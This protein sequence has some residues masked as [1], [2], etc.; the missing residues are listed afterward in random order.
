MAKYIEKYCINA[1]L[2]ISGCA[3]YAES[4]TGNNLDSP[5]SENEIESSGNSTALSEQSLQTLGLQNRVATLESRVCQYNI[6][7]VS[8][9]IDRLLCLAELNHNHCFLFSSKRLKPFSS[10]YTTISS[11]IM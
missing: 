4:E 6:I 1:I 5:V 10:D 9:I 3:V 7:C 2:F 8:V 11:F